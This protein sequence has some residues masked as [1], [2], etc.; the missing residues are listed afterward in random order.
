MHGRSSVPGLRLVLE[1]R[2]ATR[3]M[4]PLQKQMK[5]RSAEAKAERPISR[6]G[7]EPTAR[8]RDLSP[9]L[10][11]GAHLAPQERERLRLALHGGLG[12][13]LTSISFLASSLRQKL[14]DRQLPEASQAAEIL[15][16]TGRAISETQAL[17]R[18][19]DP[20]QNLAHG[21]L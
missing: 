19:D 5:P 18:E 14:D 17:V 6:N 16:L 4:P 8:Q 3:G 21:R 13:L 11:P 2:L 7:N 1:T 15:S 10:S 12:Q 9:S 20:E